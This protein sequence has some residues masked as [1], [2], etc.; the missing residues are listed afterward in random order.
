MTTKEKHK[1]ILENWYFVERLHAFNLSNELKKLSPI[2]HDM[3]WKNYRYTIDCTS[4]Y[5]VVGE[6]APNRGEI[7]FINLLYK[8]IRKE[9]K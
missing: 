2:I 5:E 3:Y 6:K 9:N 4:Q 7:L 1:W 8:L